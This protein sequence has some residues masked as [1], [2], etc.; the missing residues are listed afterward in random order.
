VTSLKCTLDETA[1]RQVAQT[2]LERAKS[3]AKSAGGFLGMG[4]TS[5]SEKKLLEEIESIL[6]V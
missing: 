2:I 5:V 6:H 1:F 3:V 4:S